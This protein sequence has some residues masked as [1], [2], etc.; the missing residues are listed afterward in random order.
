MKI[1]FTKEVTFKDQHGT[2]LRVYAV[3]EQIS[4][5]AKAG[6][7]WVTPIGGIYFDEAKEVEVL[8]K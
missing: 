4:Y 3:G 6:P 8:N 2:V 1:E 7:Y 5:T